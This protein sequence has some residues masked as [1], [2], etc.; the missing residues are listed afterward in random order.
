M[1]ILNLQSATI[2][3]TAYMSIRHNRVVKLKQYKLKVGRYCIYCHKLTEVYN[4]HIKAEMIRIGFQKYN[5]A[6]LN[7][8]EIKGSLLMQPL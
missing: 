7:G 2:N 1:L 8:A 3:N 4:K 6:C 5:I